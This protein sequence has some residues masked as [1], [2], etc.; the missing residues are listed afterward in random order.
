MSYSYGSRILYETTALRRNR[1]INVDL[2]P[3]H[4]TFTVLQDIF[5]VPTI[6]T[7]N[8]I[9]EIMSVTV[10]WCRGTTRSLS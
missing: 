3:F 2:F 5:T 8:K 4:E 9:L 6:I 10:V 1:P 7:T